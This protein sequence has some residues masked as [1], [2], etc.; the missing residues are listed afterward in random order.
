MSRNH[1]S[2]H[3][4][5]NLPRAGSHE[6]RGSQPQQKQKIR[7]FKR[8]PKL[9]L[10]KHSGDAKPPISK[11]SISSSNFISKNSCENDIDTIVSAGPKIGVIR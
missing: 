3:N 7:A 2:Q 10:Q 8:D 11:D 5:V 6:G 4:S 9:V 1:G